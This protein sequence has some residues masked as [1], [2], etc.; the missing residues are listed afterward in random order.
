MRKSSNIA[1]PHFGFGTETRG[2]SKRVME[3]MARFGGRTASGS[4]RSAQ[5]DE[6]QLGRVQFLSSGDLPASPPLFI[7]VRNGQSENDVILVP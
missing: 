1:R 4:R 3:V 7:P 5:T 2:S 6:E